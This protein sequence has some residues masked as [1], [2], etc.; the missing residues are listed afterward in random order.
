MT[1]YTF[2]F[3]LQPTFSVRLFKNHNKTE[4]YGQPFLDKRQ[5]NVHIF[6]I[7]SKIL[8]HKLNITVP[9]END[10]KT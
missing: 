6:W 4:K 8:S 3:K 9:K 1:K 7:E 2:P 10:N 5:W